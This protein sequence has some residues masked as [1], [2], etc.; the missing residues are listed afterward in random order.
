MPL[1]NVFRSE[2]GEKGEENLPAAQIKRNVKGQVL[3]TSRAAPHPCRRGWLGDT[4]LAEEA[5][6]EA[7]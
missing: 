5:L 4:V 7:G 2:V 3:G 1:K 6:T